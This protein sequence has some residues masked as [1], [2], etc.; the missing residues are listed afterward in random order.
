MENLE[1]KFEGGQMWNV[2]SKKTGH[3]PPVHLYIDTKKR[4]T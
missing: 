2:K 4:K 3:P 1:K